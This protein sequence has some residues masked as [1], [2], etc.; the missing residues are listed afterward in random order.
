MENTLGELLKSYCALSDEAH[1]LIVTDASQRHISDMISSSLP[2][3][4]STVE[5]SKDSEILNRMR[6][7]L[8]HDLLLVILG[9]DTYVNEGASRFFSPFGKPDGVTAKYAFVRLGISAESLQQGLSTPIDTVTNK[10]REMERFDPEHE[11]HIRSAAGTDI[12]L[13][14]NKFITCSHFITED[15]GYAFLPPS[16]TSSDVVLGSANGR[17]VVDVTVGQLYHYGKLLG[18]FGL[19]PSPVTITVQNGIVTDIFGC[20]MADELKS[21]L[22]ALPSECRELVELGQGLSL[23]K[24]TGLIGVDESIITTCHF[25]IGDG[26][27]CGLH[28]DVV[29]N[30]PIISVLNEEIG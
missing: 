10:I 12:R 7:L 26:A 16:E 20:S 28:L 5:F 11:I 23:M 19:V 29:I 15:G 1:V 25:G 27:K 4:C 30:S 18:E 2:N 21:K 6:G 24:P 22:F 14:A 8:P 13:R 3:E 17:I 9:F